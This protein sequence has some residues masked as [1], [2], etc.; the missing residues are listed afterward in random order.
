MKLLFV[1]H[2]H[3]YAI[4]WAYDVRS[5][6]LR[7][8]GFDAEF[9]CLV[10]QKYQGL[11]VQDESG[12]VDG[13]KFVDAVGEDLIT[14][15]KWCDAV[16]SCVGGNAHNIFGLV[17]HPRPFDFVLR[18]KAALPLHVGAE[19]VPERLVEAGLRLQGG[20]PE[21]AWVLR[22]LRLM[23]DGVII[24]CQSPPPVPDDVHL[25]K[26]A[27]V[28]QEKISQFG[29]A[30]PVLRYKLWLLHSRMVKNECQKN[31]VYFAECPSLC[32]DPNGF[33]KEEFW[34]LDTTHANPRY[35][36]IVFK[37]L[38]QMIHEFC[39]GVGQVGEWESYE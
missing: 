16:V 22:M 13:F 35:G 34:N 12:G 23:Y 14:K 3:I 9:V 37:E 4:K 17:N 31:K 11:R 32:L 1:G 15:L 21:S 25:L 10:E 39:G 29:L 7:A 18:E 19:V 30:P 8:A 2:S 24:H 27:G 28:F 6:R 20:F 38:A 26:Y 36:W 5:S 33:L